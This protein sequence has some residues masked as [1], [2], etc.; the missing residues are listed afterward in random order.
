MEI[1][2]AGNQANWKSWLTEQGGSFLQ[3]WEWGEILV[4]EGKTVEQLQMVDGGI[5]VAQA[6]VVYTNLPVGWKYG[7]C[8][9][10]PVITYHVAHN[11]YQGTDNNFVSEV[12]QCLTNFVK[13]NIT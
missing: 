13:E 3:S 7:F 10:G 11:T 5:V 6:Q 9:G 12:Y 1:S 2:L 4:S 8:A